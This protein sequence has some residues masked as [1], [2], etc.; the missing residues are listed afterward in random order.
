MAAAPPVGRPLVGEKGDEIALHGVAIHGLA[1]GQPLRGVQLG[2]VLGESKEVE[3]RVVPGVPV[4]A[5]HRAL[6][7]GESAVGVGVAPED[8][9]PGIHLD[10]DRVARTGDP[11]V[12]GSDAEP[13]HPGLVER[14]V[15]EDGDRLTPGPDRSVRLAVQRDLVRRS[16]AGRPVLAQVFTPDHQLE[17]LPG[18]DDGGRNTAHRPHPGAVYRKRRP[19]Q[20]EVHTRAVRVHIQRQ[21]DVVVLGA[22]HPEAS[23]ATGPVTVDDGQDVS[24]RERVPLESKGEVGLGAAESA[25]EPP[26]RNCDLGEL[27]PGIRTAEGDIVVARG[28]VELKSTLVGKEVLSQQQHATG[29]DRQLADGVALLDGLPARGGE[30]SPGFQGDGAQRAAQLVLEPHL[31]YERVEILGP[32]VFVNRRPSCDDPGRRLR[33]RTPGQREG[34]DP[35][36]HHLAATAQVLGAGGFGRELGLE[37]LDP[38]PQ[39]W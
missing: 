2:V 17:R 13:V 20:R 3:A 16:R 33:N 35:V 5:V 21:H 32:T 6:A 14:D 31:V 30:D 12:G 27:R 15:A 19:G 8:P 4:D 36:P 34:V 18:G 1:N 22:L 25:V 28:I 24:P 9:V 39:L 7:V 10:P 23:G 37:P 26:P 11:A 29:G 38:P